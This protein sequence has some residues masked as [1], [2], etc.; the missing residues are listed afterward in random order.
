MR[1]SFHRQ[2]AG[3]GEARWGWAT[4]IVLLVLLALRLASILL[5]RADLYADEAQYWRWS[6]ELAW[7]YYSKPPLIAWVIAAST[8]LFG[9]AEWAIRLPAPLLHTA[10]A[11]FLYLAGRDMF[12]PRTGFLAAVGYALMPGIILSSGLI[13][14]DGVL[15]PIWCLALWL[16]WRLREGRAGWLGAAGLGLAIGFGLL[17]KYAGLYFL[18]GLAL[19]ALIDPPM[20]RALLSGRGALAG[21]LAALIIAP[22][23][24]WNAANDFATVGHTVDNANLSGPL[25]NPENLAKFLV[26]Q[27]AVAGPVVVV[28]LLLGLLTFLRR[29]SG[30]EAPRARW[31]ICFILPVLVL[32]AVQA[33]VS[34][35]HANWAAT[36]YPAAMILVAAWLDRGRAIAWLWPAIAALTL[37]A[38]LLIPDVSLLFRILLGAGFGLAILSFGWGFRG[39]PVGLLWLS[40]A[41]HFALAMVLA[42][43]VIGPA[44]LTRSLGLDNALKRTRGWD[45][46]AAAITRA[47]IDMDASAVL[48]DEREVWHGID[49]YGRNRLDVPLIAW[50][51]NAGIKSFSERAVLTGEIDD[52][53]LVASLRPGLRP[54]I[55]ADFATFRH[56]GTIEIVLGERANGCP[57]LRRLEL[58][59]ASG[60]APMERDQAW[61]KRFEGQSERVNPP[62]P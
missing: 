12:S 14:T 3:T 5:S 58:Y 43:L 39:R 30:H 2:A 19:T 50:R 51:R 9:H 21:L 48:V 36:A 27:M 38:I 22:H 45:E 56:V 31:L 29:A 7:G 42:I 37:I 10:G 61:E 53:V 40:F 20:R 34:R 52:A 55:R 33:V 11:A 13:S 32:I 49:Y 24:A 8:S 23:L 1:T 15:L 16:A 62:C 47:A 6:R 4:L 35:A 28:T 57:I 60:H 18:I 54:R 17:A 26:D 25:F 41:F 44:T 59:R 46:T